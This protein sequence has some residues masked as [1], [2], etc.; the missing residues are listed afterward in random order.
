M[1]IIRREFRRDLQ[2]IVLSIKIA[3]GLALG[4][5]DEKLF[6][7]Q[8]VKFNREE[9]EKEEDIILSSNFEGDLKEELIL[10]CH[11]V[12]FCKLLASS[13]GVYPESDL[14]SPPPLTTLIQTTIIL[15]WIY[16]NSLLTGRVSFPSLPY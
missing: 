15:L 7:S 5:I 13:F 11:M 3:V 10:Q 2:S 6:H 16:C 14:L 1:Q 9:R 8:K 12:R 4:R